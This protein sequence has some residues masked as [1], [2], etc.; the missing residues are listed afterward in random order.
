M[1]VGLSLILIAA[2]AILVWG[3]SATVAGLDV[4]AIGVILMV[5]GIV[6]LILS[7]VFW[8]TWGGFGG[9]TRRESDGNTTTVVR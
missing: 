9:G 5:V 8:S 7:L 4:N 1:G 6:G 3:V 2:G